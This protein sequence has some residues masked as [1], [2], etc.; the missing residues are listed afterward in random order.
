MTDFDATLIPVEEFALGW[1]PKTQVSKNFKLY[2]L[3]KSETADRLGID[4]SFETVYQLRNAVFTCRHVLQPIRDHFGSFSPNSVFRCQ[5]L[6]RAIKEKPLTWTSS[7]Q[8]TTGEAADYEVP[9]V[10][11][12]MLADWVEKNLVFDQLILECY[13]KKNGPN[14]GWI[15][16]SRRKDQNRMNVRSY[17]KHANKYVYVDGLEETIA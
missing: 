10:P 8:H 7:S 14:S 16:T 13:N 5:Q 15:H 17:I 2:E 11:N 3:T 1:S 9:G 6:E 12:M 4:N